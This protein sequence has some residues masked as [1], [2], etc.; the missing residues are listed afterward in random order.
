MDTLVSFKVDTY[1]DAGSDNYTGVVKVKA[2]NQW[3]VLCG[4]R[5]SKDAADAVCKMAGIRS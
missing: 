4:R 1:L 5:F 3:A 2:N